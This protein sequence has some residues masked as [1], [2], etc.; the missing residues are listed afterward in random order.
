M[1]T[2]DPGPVRILACL[3]AAGFFIALPAYLMGATFPVLASL[4]P[5]GM[6]TTFTYVHAFW[7]PRARRFRHRL[8]CF[9][10]EVKTSRIVWRNVP[11]AFVYRCRLAVE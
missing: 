8:E 1:G 11:P 7:L 5:D 6:F 10:A 2:S 3:G 9:F 4:A